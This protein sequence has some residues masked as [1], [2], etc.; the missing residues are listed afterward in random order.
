MTKPQREALTAFTG[1]GMTIQIAYEPTLA[2]SDLFL[3]ELIFKTTQSISSAQS[4][5]V[6]LL[7]V[8][9]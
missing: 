6:A 3:H 5:Q 9:S 4:S 1:N 2:T 7:S 8:F